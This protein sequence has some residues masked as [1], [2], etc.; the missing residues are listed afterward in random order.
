MVVL[1]GIDKV[2]VAKI[3]ALWLKTAIFGNFEGMCS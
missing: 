3:A 2:K 1:R